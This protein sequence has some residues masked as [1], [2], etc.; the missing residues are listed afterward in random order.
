MDPLNQARMPQQQY[1]NYA[2]PDRQM[3]NGNHQQQMPPHNEFDAPQQL[4]ATGNGQIQQQTAAP[5]KIPSNEQS[6][7]QQQNQ[8]QGGS[9]SSAA[10]SPNVIHRLL[11]TVVTAEIVRTDVKSTMVGTHTVY[12]IKVND[13]DKTKEVERRFDD[14][15]NLH[16]ELSRICGAD[17]LS[18]LPE[19]GWF[20]STDAETVAVRK[21]ITSCLD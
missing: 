8:Q 14:F 6:V 10:N 13:F 2:P 16:Q 1:D 3:G 21:P 20:K 19:K 9:S 17:A 15:N 12:V 11:S 5:Q 4:P 7:P 18:P